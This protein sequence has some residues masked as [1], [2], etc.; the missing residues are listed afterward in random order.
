MK[1]AWILHHK[2]TGEDC[3]CSSLPVVFTL[4]PD[5]EVYRN[6]IYRMAGM[7]NEDYVLK[8]CPMFRPSDV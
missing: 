5:L 2:D 4:A 6:R 8:H 7:E 1:G 3:I